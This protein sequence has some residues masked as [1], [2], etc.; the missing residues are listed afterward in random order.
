MR[1]LLALVR[2]DLLN[3]QLTKTAFR[4]LLVDPERFEL[5]T[6]SMPLRRAPNCAMGPYLLSSFVSHGA[7]NSP[8]R[9]LRALWALIYYLLLFPTA[10]PIPPGGDFVRYGSLFTIFFCFPRRSQFPQEGTSCAMGPGF[11]YMDLEGFEPSTSSVRLKR[12]PNCATGP[13]SIQI[14][15]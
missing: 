8:G 7:P 11:F 14:S 6:F 10:L 3:H 9:G 2:T 12:A 15:R 5:S 1:S 13:Y 4:L